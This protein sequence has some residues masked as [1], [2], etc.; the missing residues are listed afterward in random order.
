[1]PAPTSTMP[2]LRIESTASWMVAKSSG[3]STVGRTSPPQPR[4]G[5]HRSR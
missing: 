1:V 3:T 5:R 4:P 2:P